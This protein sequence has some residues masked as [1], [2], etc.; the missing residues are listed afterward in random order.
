MVWLY[1]TLAGMAL[2]A[3]GLP[4]LVGWSVSAVVI[5]AVA[6]GGG[7]AVQYLIWRDAYTSAA[8]RRAR[9]TPLERRA[10]IDAG[11]RYLRRALPGYGV[12]V[13]VALGAFWASTGDPVGIEALILFAPLVPMAG[14]YFLSRKR[15]GGP[16]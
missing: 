5:G 12:A 14:W 11:R 4:L 10:A 9:M 15:T 16:R 7:P 1:I 2:G 6:G 3:V 13:L 8:E